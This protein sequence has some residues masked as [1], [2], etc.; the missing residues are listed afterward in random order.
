VPADQLVGFGTASDDT[1][2]IALVHT[3]GSLTAW[4]TRT[5]ARLGNPVAVPGTFSGMTWSRPG[6]PGQAVVATRSQFELWDVPGGRRLGSTA[7]TVQ[8]YP[9]VVVGPD[10]LVAVTPDANLEVRRLPDME[11]VGAPIFAPGINQLLGFDPEGKL[12]ATAR[13][14]IGEQI[15]LWDLDRR[16]EVGRITLTYAVRSEVDGAS[17][18]VT[19]GSGRLPEVHPLLAR[20]WQAH[21]CRLL[22]GEPSAGATA[23]FPAGTD[24]SS[25]CGSS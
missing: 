23:L 14:G 19:A 16:M 15:A 7:L 21:L 2:E 24:R 5:G 22:P 13:D 17:I 1:T 4:D 9:G 10:I 6:H 12:V 18:S 20:D 25:P 3:P 8:G 11:L